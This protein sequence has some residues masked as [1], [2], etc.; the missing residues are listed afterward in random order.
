MIDSTPYISILNCYYDDVTYLCWLW[1][2]GWWNVI[3]QCRR[4]DAIMQQMASLQSNTTPPK[5]ISWQNNRCNTNSSL[6]VRSLELWIDGLRHR[7]PKLWHFNQQHSIRRCRKRSK[8]EYCFWI[9]I[10]AK[11]RAFFRL[12]INHSY[13]SS[14]ERFNLTNYWWRYEILLFWWLSEH[15]GMDIQVY[16]GIYCFFMTILSF[17]NYYIPWRQCWYKNQLDPTIIGGVVYYRS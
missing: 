8:M 2:H 16:D 9:T 7:D 11:S 5:L 10:L 12:I 14:Q 17:C 1:S 15:G 6:L 3:F 4:T 13:Y